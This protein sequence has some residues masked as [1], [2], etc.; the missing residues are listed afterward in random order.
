MLKMKTTSNGKQPLW[1]EDDQKKLK[2]GK[3]T[4]V[5]EPIDLG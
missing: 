3:S 1:V 5:S 4:M 2:L